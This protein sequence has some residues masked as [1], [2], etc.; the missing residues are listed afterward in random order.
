MTNWRGG[1]IISSF[2]QA[3]YFAP[4]GK[5]RLTRLGDRISQRYLVP[6]DSLIG[7]IG[8][9]GA[10]KSLLIRGMF[11]GL[12]LTNDDTGINIRP[13]PILD[14]AEEGEFVSH[15]YH[16]D[17]R[18]ES[19]FTQPW[20]LAEAI[21]EAIEQGCRVVIEH[22]E[23]LADHLELKADLLLGIGEEILVTRPGIFGPQPEEIAKIVFNSIVNRWMAHTAEDLTTHVLQEMNVENPEPDYHSDIKSGFV[24]HFKNKLEVD[25]SQVEKKVQD[26]IAQDVIVK[27]HD[28]QHIKVGDSIYT[29]TGPRIHVDSTGQITGFRLKDLEFD[30]KTGLY[31]L[32]GL[33]G[34]EES[35]F[36]L[37]QL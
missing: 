29:C 9:A 35:Q 16:V 31:L 24:L 13:L 2:A 28:E 32:A 19:A 36:K 18:F 15:T 17:A 22:F 10:G 4:R 20:K 14:Q 21:I 5:K 25:I 8:D 23:L 26:Y 30:P 37:S 34:E 3:V 12:T 27:S 1:I 33:V 7:V 11:P 6:E